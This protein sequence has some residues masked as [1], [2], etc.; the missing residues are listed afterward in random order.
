MGAALGTLVADDVV[1][2]AIAETVEEK[3]WISSIIATW[4]NADYTPGEGPIIVGLAH[5]DYTAAEIEEFLEN[6]GSW[7]EGNKVAQEVA[8]RKIKIV[9][10]FALDPTSAT[11]ALNAESLND[12]KAM[13]TKL[14]WLL[15]TGQTVDVWAW[16]KSGANLTTGQVVRVQGHANLWPSG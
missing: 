16:N 10:T 2:T 1:I 15:T 13:R 11:A 5:S 14:N 6:T 12:G 9:G 3:T 4:V 8:R 7:S